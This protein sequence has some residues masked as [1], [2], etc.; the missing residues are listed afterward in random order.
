MRDR[1]SW[2]PALKKNI[3]LTNLWIKTCLERP[4]VFSDHFSMAEGVV[5]QDRF[6][7]T[8]TIKKEMYK[9]LTNHCFIVV[10]M[11]K[12]VKTKSI[13]VQCNFRSPV[14]Q[15]NI[16]SPVIA[17]PFTAMTV[18]IYSTINSRMTKSLTLKPIWKSS[19]LFNKF[20][21]RTHL[22]ESTFT[23]IYFSENLDKKLSIYHWYF[24]QN[25][26]I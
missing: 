17:T 15:C 21:L 23:F 2:E 4:P 3:F 12:S 13:G 5:S 20:S 10:C 11:A 18:Q 25:Y 22:Q 6:H 8:S 1:L 9:I 24:Y 19:F 14:E 7:C 16:Q 26:F